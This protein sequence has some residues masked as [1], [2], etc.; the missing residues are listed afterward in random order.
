MATLGIPPLDRLLGVPRDALAVLRTLQD[1]SRYTEAMQSHT[2]MLPEVTRFLERVADDTAELPA[3]NEE[4]ARVAAAMALIAQMDGRMATIERAMPT[5]VDVQKHLVELPET[6]GALDAR[7]GH[8]SEL[9]ERM[10]SS[11]EGLARSVDALQ[12]AVGPMA[13]LA[14]RL[15]G[16]RASDR[17]GREEDPQAS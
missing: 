9:L 17:A 13:R 4:M 3:L 7:M 12:V 14:G 15:P 8:L 6:V 5:L 10:L 1:I 11:M 2:A 16:R